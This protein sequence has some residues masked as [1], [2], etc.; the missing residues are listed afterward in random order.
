M[1]GFGIFVTGA[2]SSF[3]K[4]VQPV[5][6]KKRERITQ[7]A[8]SRRGM[9]DFFGTECILKQYFIAYNLLPNIK[10]IQFIRREN[11]KCIKISD[12][13]ADL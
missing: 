9:W 10:F 4:P 11:G 7:K 2:A 12:K 13:K 3:K 5:R 6:E 1:S 8:D